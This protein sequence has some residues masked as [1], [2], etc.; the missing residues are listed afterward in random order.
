MRKSL[1]GSSGTSGTDSTSMWSRTPE[2]SRSCTRHRA[3]RGT[4]DRPLRGDELEKLTLCHSRCSRR[5]SHTFSTRVG[6][7]RCRRVRSQSCYGLKLKVMVRSLRSTSPLVILN[8][9]ASLIPSPMVTPPRTPVSVVANG[10][11]IFQKP[12]CELT[13]TA[14]TTRAP[15][16]SE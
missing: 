5:C 16:D 15:G 2:C 6:Q 10:F 9:A 7:R 11:S 3:L 1:H 14:K 8:P 13:Q 4:D 12:W